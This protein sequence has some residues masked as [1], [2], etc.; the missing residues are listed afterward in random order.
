MSEPDRV[1]PKRV[2]ARAS[3]KS[4]QQF[5]D[6]LWKNNSEEG[7]WYFHHTNDAA[8]YGEH[9]ADVATQ[10]ERERAAKR[11]ELA[12]EKVKHTSHADGLGMGWQALENW[13]LEEAA[14]IRGNTD[15]E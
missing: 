15:A 14:A 1:P 8:R 10:R 5:K 12:A 7:P 6:W 4:H 13:L 11:L 9:R 3:V 2:E